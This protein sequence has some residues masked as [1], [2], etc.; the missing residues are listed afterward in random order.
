MAGTVSFTDATRVLT[1][2]GAYV[3]LTRSPSFLAGLAQSAFS[4]RSA[5]VI[6][7]Q[8][9]ASDLRI[10]AGWAEAARLKSAVQDTVDYKALPDAYRM[11]GPEAP[12]PVGIEL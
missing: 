4:R 12:G 7:V 5:H 10:L 9:V 6:S 1:E 3:T 11:V 2:A 8:S